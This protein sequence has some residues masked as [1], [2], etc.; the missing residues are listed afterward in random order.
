MREFTIAI[1]N[2]KYAPNGECFFNYE[3]GWADS[4]GITAEDYDDVLR[5]LQRARQDIILKR[6]Q[7]VNKEI[8]VHKEIKEITGDE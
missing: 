2:K 6:S 7:I 1:D 5:V 8:Q 3:L 4:N